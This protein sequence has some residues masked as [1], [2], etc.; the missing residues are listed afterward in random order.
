MIRSTLVLIASL[1][2][3]L[4][5]TT[6][7]EAGKKLYVGN[8]PY[9]STDKVGAFDPSTVPATEVQ[10]LS[11]SLQDARTGT[12]Q[13]PGDPLASSSSLSIVNPGPDG[14][15]DAASLK[16]SWSG[17]GQDMPQ[18][19]FFVLHL[20]ITDPGTGQP[21]ELKNGEVKFFNEAKG[22]GMIVS[23]HVPGEPEYFYSLTGEINPAQSGLSFA[24]VPVIPGGGSSFFDIF[25]EL[26]YDGLGTINPDLP[27]FEIT[28]TPVPEPSTLLLA[29]AGM[30]ALMAVARKRRLRTV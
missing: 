1:A 9:S 15:G 8:L 20:A 10:E 12:V 5:F 21:T 30:A 22:F 17:P 7:A 14:L 11:L 16:V 29:A 2:G 27:L 24:N 25:T 4:A 18:E 23:G 26:R 13:N 3:V 6:E 28:L 19:S